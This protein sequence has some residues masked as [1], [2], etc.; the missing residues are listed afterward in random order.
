ML[1][2]RLKVDV[3]VNGTSAWQ[4]LA[5]K[6]LID[7]EI[8]PILNPT[9][10]WGKTPGVDVESYTWSLVCVYNQLTT[11]GVTRDPGQ[12]LVES[13]Q[14]A[15]GDAAKL[16]VRWYDRNGLAEAWQGWGAV[17]VQRNASGVP[18]LSQIRVTFTADGDLTP[19]ANPG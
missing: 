17:T 8:V 2:R 13:C 14:A 15:V 7:P 9:T 1:A 19:I 5:A 4:P 18:D 6:V 11:T 12:A 10:Q 3:S 16:W